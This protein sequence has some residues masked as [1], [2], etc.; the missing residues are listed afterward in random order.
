[1]KKIVKLALLIIFID[2]VNWCLAQQHIKNVIIITTD[3]FRWQEVFTGVDRSLAASK[4]FNQGDSAEI[5]KKY[6]DISP[7][8]SRAKILPFIWGTIAKQGQ[9]YG[10]RN[11]GNLMN[12]ANP[13]WF[14]Y[15]GYNEILT[16]FPDVQVNSNN[17][18][19][20]PN[21]S[22]LDFLSRKDAYKGRVAAYASWN[23]FDRILNKPGANFPVVAAFEKTG[24]EHP[25]V[26]EELINKM[27]AGSYKPFGDEECLDV[28]THYGAMEYM[29]Q[30]KPRVMFIGYG[31]TDEW[32]HAGKYY[33]YLNAA[34]QV[35][36]WLND[37]WTYI[38]SDPFYKDQTALL[39]TT[40]HGRGSAAEWT[41]HGPKIVGAD[42]IWFA[43]IGPGIAA[44]GEIRNTSQNY[45][46]QLAQTIA[47]LL[48]TKFTA[49]HPVADQINIPVK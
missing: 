24:G 46:K 15:P 17:Y 32:A 49:E 21:Q 2:P 22:L 43:L 25:S 16:G 20:N 34:H 18:K 41:S 36:Q 28:F 39:I 5:F 38:Q 8:I 47:A 19:N 37:I 48:G 9:I 13:Y 4:R 30:H 31:E 42:Q 1:M 35:D 14:S 45:Q 23:A 44:R 11:A 12:V 6:G 3:G 27:L 7:E 29:Q 26:K 40:D 33:D 10:N